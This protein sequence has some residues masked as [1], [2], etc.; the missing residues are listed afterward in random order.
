MHL[1]ALPYI[2]VFVAAIVEGEIVFVGASALAAHGVLDPTGVL[3]AGALGGSAGDQAYFYVA[4][5]LRGRSSTWLARYR[6]LAHRRDAVV[7]RVR[8]HATL[9]ILACRFLPGLRIAIPVACAYA[10]VRPQRFS[11]LSVL[12]SMCWAA[13]IMGLVTGSHHAWL[14]LVGPARGWTL[15]VPLTLLVLFVRWLGHLPEHALEQQGDRPLGD[16][17]DCVS[18]QGNP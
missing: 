3:V 18:G 2:G 9:M 1:S 14:N 8:Q 4:R 7:R 16:D 15:L 17:D 12:S 5:S 11:S 6:G 10:G 13:A